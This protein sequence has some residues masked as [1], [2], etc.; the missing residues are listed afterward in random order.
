MGWLWSIDDEEKAK[1]ESDDSNYPDTSG[2]E[3][4]LGMAKKTARGIGVN[5]DRQI[6]DIATA[7]A[8]QEL[9]DRNLVADD[10]EY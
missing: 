7:K 1:E 6:R 3:Q 4:R 5:D 8:Q 10:S 2:Q 9:E